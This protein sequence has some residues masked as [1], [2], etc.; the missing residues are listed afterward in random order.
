MGTKNNPGAYDCYENA[1]PDEPMF[2]LLGRDPIG[3]ALVRLW[4]DARDTLK[5]G[6][7]KIAEAAACA[8]AMEAWC[9]KAERMPERNVLALLPFAHLAAELERRG[10][11]V[12]PAQHGGDYEDAPWSRDDER[13][14]C[15]LLLCGG[16]DVTPEAIAAWTDEQCQQAEDW[17]GRE[18]LHASDNDD[19]ERVPMPPHVKAHPPKPSSGGLW[20]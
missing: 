13:T 10:A 12:T 14:L 5:P 9:R 3:G 16:H 1:H 11:T 20:D 18:H 19:V 6:D 4:C 15:I 2:V 7:P 17:A 8:E